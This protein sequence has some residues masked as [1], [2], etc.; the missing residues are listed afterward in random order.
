MGNLNAG[1]SVDEGM[2]A[3]EARSLFILRSPEGG[4]VAR[5]EGRPGA[6]FG[7]R[8]IDHP[9]AGNE[10]DESITRLFDE[11]YRGL[12]RLAGLML[13]DSAGA[14]EVVQ[15]AFLR[16]FSGWWRVRYPERAQW[17]LRKSVVNL[18]RSRLRRRGTEERGNRTTWA[19]E[20]SRP[21]SDTPEHSDDSM[22]L[23]EHVRRLPPRQREAVILRYYEDLPEAE[24]ARMLGCAVGTVKSQLAKARTTLARTISQAS[25]DSSEPSGSSDISDLADL[26]ERGSGEG[27]DEVSDH[28]SSPGSQLNESRKPGEGKSN[29]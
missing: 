17:Y 27:P 7:P 14:E 16:T 28:T 19:E 23:A 22:L 10:R 13:G 4:A 9:S 8:V 26:S 3:Q 12:C 1:W 11:H 15:E 18:C 21:G 2:E 29:V 20:V 6:T 5:A 24:I 25:E